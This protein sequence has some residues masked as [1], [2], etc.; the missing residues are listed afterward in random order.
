M[1]VLLKEEKDKKIQDLNDELQKER[2]RST[3]IQ[4]QLHLIIKDLEQHAEF[5]SLRVED[6]VN[7]MKQIELDDL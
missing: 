4:R 7:N 1:W 3:E 2:D 5:M 6:I